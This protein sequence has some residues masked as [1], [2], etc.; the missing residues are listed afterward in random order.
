GGPALGAAGVSKKTKAAKALP[1]DSPYGWPRDKT[2][3]YSRAHGGENAD[4]ALTALVNAGKLPVRIEWFDHQ[5]SPPRQHRRLLSAADYEFGPYIRSNFLLVQPRCPDVPVLPR[6]HALSFWGPK[7][8]QHWPLEEA[9]PVSTKQQAADPLAPSHPR[10]AQRS[11][12]NK[13]Q[14]TESRTRVLIREIADELWKS[15]WENITTDQIRTDVGDVLKKRHIKV[16]GRD[17][18]LRAL[19]RRKDKARL[20]K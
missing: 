17:T 1:L 10:R 9:E 20:R 13:P 15:G 16:P 5:I 14:R 3:A 19:G 11:I 6:P 12:E 7:L 8:H 2:V 18:F 4:T